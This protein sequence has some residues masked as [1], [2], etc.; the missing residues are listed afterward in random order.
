MDFGQVVP[1]GNMQLGVFV[2]QCLQGP[3]HRV[4]VGLPAVYP[5]VQ[6]RFQ[7]R[8]LGVRLGPQPLA[9]VGGGGPGHGYHHA[10]YGG[11]HQP[12][13]AAVVQPQG[14]GLL[15]ARQY[16]FDR[17]CAA[18]DLQPGQPGPGVVLA[19]LEHPGTQLRPDRRHAGQRLQT[20]QQF[21][22]PVQP[23]RRAKIAGKYLPPGNGLYQRVVSRCA[24]GQ[25]FFHQ[26]FTAQGQGFGVRCAGKIH[27]AVPE[28]PPQLPQ[29]QGGIGPRQ[30]H[31]VDKHKGGHPVAG[32]QFPQGF[33]VGL[34]AVS[35]A[36]D[37]HRIV[38]HLQGPLGLGGK[39]HVARRVQQGQHRFLGVAAGGQRENRLFGKN[40]NAPGPLLGVGVQKGVPVVHPAQLAQRPCPVQKPFGQGGFAAV[41]V[42]Q[43]PR[44][45]ALLGEFPGGF[46]HNY[47]L[48]G[49]GAKKCLPPK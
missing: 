22:Q 10:G 7:Q 24:V 46:G 45:D 32:Q 48:C 21:V 16:G 49:I 25:H 27:A 20:V 35:A 36:D 14:I 37:Q 5:V 26:R 38:Q 19:D 33:G 30:V 6:H 9:G 44:Y 2:F 47:L 8:C 15:T 31:L 34:H 39:I 12:E 1:P 4:G 3:Q 29:A 42:G 43:Q 13:L 28:A 23:Q 40:R 17:Q 41:H 11:V 18:G